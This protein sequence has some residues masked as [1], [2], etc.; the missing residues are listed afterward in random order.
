MILILNAIQTI[1]CSQSNIQSSV[2]YHIGIDYCVGIEYDD[3][4]FDCNTNDI[5]FSKQYGINF[6]IPYWNWY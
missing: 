1:S 3:F 2:Q 4:N 5:T 6:P